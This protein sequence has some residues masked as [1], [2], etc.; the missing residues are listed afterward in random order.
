MIGT[1]EV[2]KVMFGL[3]EVSSLSMGE[4]TIPITPPTTN[5]TLVIIDVEE[6]I[7]GGQ[8]RGCGINNI[9]D[10]I[11]SWDDIEGYADNSLDVYPP[12]SGSYD[13]GVIT[14]VGP[15]SGSSYTIHFYGLTENVCA[16][17]SNDTTFQFSGNTEEIAAD[18]TYELDPECDCINQGGEWDGSD[19][20]YPEPDPCEGMGEEE[21]ECVQ[22]GGTWVIPEIGDPYCEQYDPCIDDPC[23]CDPNPDECYCV[24][25]GGIWNGSDCE[26]PPEEPME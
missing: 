6:A 26:Y 20:I 23:S 2:L 16:P 21:C 9:F 1:D 3:D 10:F 7:Q 17:I 8:D 11:S 22:N 18:F 14:I 4:E 24:Q 19:C 5:K 15:F 12:F 13:N 25:N